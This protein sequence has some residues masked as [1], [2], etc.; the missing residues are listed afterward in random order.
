MAAADPTCL[1]LPCLSAEPQLG[2]PSE[3]AGGP[4]VL[5]VWESCL[6]G[7]PVC[8]SGVRLTGCL[9]TLA[10][11]AV[12]LS[13]W[14]IFRANR[15]V[16]YESGHPS[17]QI[18]VEPDFQGKSSENRHENALKIGVLAPKWAFVVPKRHKN[19]RESQPWPPEGR[20]V[21]QKGPTDGEM[22]RCF[23][24][25]DRFYTLFLEPSGSPYGI[26]RTASG[27]SRRR[28]GPTEPKTLPSFP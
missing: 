22:C 21:A 10:V 12:W 23:F 27:N 6:S 25:F 26:P 1:T 7:N 14:A 11:W 15:Q 19:S 17:I 16:D 8:L 24:F 28:R 13:S 20:I 9:A 2:R 18:E 4:S 3:A 5:S